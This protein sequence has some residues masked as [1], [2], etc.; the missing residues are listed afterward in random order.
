MYCDSS[1]ILARAG[2]AAAMQL[3]GG[4]QIASPMSTYAS[5]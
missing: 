5:V 4:G 3:V 2:G 1:I